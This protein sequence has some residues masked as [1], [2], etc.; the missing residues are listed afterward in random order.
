MIAPAQ[1]TRT[2][3]RVLIMGSAVDITGGKDDIRRLCI[4]CIDPLVLFL[5]NT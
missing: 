3:I 5:T 4:S 2:L 1:L